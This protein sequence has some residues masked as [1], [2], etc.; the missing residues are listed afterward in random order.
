MYI[1]YTAL[2]LGGVQVITFI[3][4]CCLICRIPTKEEKEQ[5][6]LDEARRMNRDPQNYNT[7]SSGYNRV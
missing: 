6:L 5:A 1:A 7:T 2:I 3:I 4:T